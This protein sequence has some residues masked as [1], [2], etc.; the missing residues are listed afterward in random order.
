MDQLKNI[1]E[2]GIF[3]VCSALGDRMGIRISTVR[4]YFIYLS[5]VTMGSP[6]VIYLFV[7]FWMNLKN[8]LNQGVR[9]I[10]D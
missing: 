9:T 8:Y 3:G 2:K 7:A 4:L 5:F 10:I 1:V 6:I